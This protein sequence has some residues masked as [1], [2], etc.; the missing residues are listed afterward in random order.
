MD[1]DLFIF[2]KK[3]YQT[4]CHIHLRVYFHLYVL[5]RSNKWYAI[6]NKYELLNHKDLTKLTE[7]KEQSLDKFSFL[8][9][10]FLPKVVFGTKNPQNMCFQTNKVIGS[11]F[12]SLL[13]RKETNA[14]C[15]LAEDTL[16]SFYRVGLS[17]YLW[18]G[19]H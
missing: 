2:L 18:L 19:R 1:S 6:E 4:W 11:I 3:T 15:P 10:L 17:K 8:L 9:K 7:Y 12:I 13:K 5:D 16:K 14:L